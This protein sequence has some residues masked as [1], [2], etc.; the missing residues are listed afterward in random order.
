MVKIIESVVEEVV[1]SWFEELG[2]GYVYG[3][4]IIGE[5]ENFEWDDYC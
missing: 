1:I 5:V 3:F 2:Y 4:D